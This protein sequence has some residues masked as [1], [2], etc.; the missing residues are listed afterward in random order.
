MEREAEYIIYIF[1]FPACFLILARICLFGK[2]GAGGGE[3]HEA[4]KSDEN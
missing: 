1:F 2:R 3:G 4:L